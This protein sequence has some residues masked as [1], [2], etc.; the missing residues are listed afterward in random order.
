MNK[1]VIGPEG[2]VDLR[3]QPEPS[4]TVTVQ[5]FTPEPAA[6]RKLP[7][8]MIQEPPAPVKDEP[9]AGRQTTTEGLETSVAPPV[10][11]PAS[12]APVKLLR[13]DSVEGP[14]CYAVMGAKQF[15]R[16]GRHKWSGSRTGHMYRI[17]V[18]ATGTKTVLW[19][20]RE[21]ARCNRVDKYVAFL[22]GDERNLTW[23]NLQ[24]VSTKEEAKAVRRTA[25]ES[26]ANG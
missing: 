5:G 21:A 3:R 25:L 13:I 1:L 24:I 17:V 10:A 11:V 8:E 9:M 14:P 12:T 16:L 7:V 18:S 22:D 23:K 26:V 6:P 2:F 4:T 15:E 19:L 20:H